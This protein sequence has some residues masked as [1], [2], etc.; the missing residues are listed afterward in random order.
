MT[1]HKIKLTIQLKYLITKVKNN[2]SAISEPVTTQA[3]NATSLASSQ[4]R[5]S[6]TNHIMQIA[7]THQQEWPVVFTFPTERVSFTLQDILKDPKRELNE[8]EL[9]EMTGVLHDKIVQ[10]QRYVVVLKF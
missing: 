7:S 2:L 10:F 8:S 3:P 1:K 5:A 6:A 4:Q 9:R